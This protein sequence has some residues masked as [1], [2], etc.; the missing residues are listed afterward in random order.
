MPYE[1]LLEIEGS[2][3][4]TK[5]VIGSDP[6]T[7]DIIIL[8]PHFD[9]AVIALGGMIG[10][11]VANGRTVEI[12]T[13]FTE[14][15]ALETIPAAQQ[16]LGDYATRRE[17]DRRALA[18]LGASHRWLN[19]RERIW[20]DPP[21]RQDHHIF[22][23][24][25]T[26]EGFTTLPAL[27]AI[28]RQLILGRSKLFAPLGAG[29]HHDHIEVALAVLL[30]MLSQ[31]RFDRV[32][33]YEDP[34]AQG[35]VCRRSHF[36]TRRRLWKP[37]AAPAWASPRMGALLF[38]AAMCARGPQVEDYVPEVTQLP[39]SCTDVPVAPEEERRKLAAAAEYTSQVKAFGGERV[40]SA[41]M[42]QAHV[43]LNGEPIWRVQTHGA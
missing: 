23:T 41:F 21:L 39:W 37:G 34:Y 22:H 3:P 14:G 43:A 7:P 10:R 18:V 38:A 31:R 35:G 13:C 1:S 12:W 5:N 4:M 27:R 36:V 17:E 30:E 24:P 2:D 25:P 11:E 15:P 20:R 8:S 19:L 6:R 16:V 29:H 32:H 33:F 40:V 42:R 28:V 9:D 26:L